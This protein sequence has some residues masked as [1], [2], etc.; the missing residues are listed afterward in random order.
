MKHPVHKTQNKLSAPSVGTIIIITIYKGELFTVLNTGI[1]WYSPP[2]S[3]P[4]IPEIMV[5][6][7]CRALHRLQDPPRPRTWWLPSLSWN[8]LHSCGCPALV[9]VLEFLRSFL[10]HPAV[11]PVT[12]C[13]SQ[14]PSPCVMCVCCC[15]IPGSSVSDTSPPRLSL[16]A[17]QAGQ[18]P[19]PRDGKGLGPYLDVC[20]CLCLSCA[21]LWEQNSERQ[22]CLCPGKPYLKQ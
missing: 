6:V 22:T 9:C 19:V 3:F 7:K 21:F 11:L 13:L 15:W 10:P 17:T 18:L 12:Q 14:H 5:D 20:E 16:P 4:D 1:E 2:D 8:L